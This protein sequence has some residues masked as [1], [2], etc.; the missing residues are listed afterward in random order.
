MVRGRHADGRPR[1]VLEL[2]AAGARPM[3]RRQFQFLNLSLSRLCQLLN[4]SERIRIAF[5]KSDSKRPRNRREAEE[6]PDNERA[7]GARSLAGGTAS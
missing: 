5:E 4:P 2:A 3:H 7:G 6:N 1:P